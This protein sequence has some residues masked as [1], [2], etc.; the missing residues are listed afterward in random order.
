[1]N[2]RSH[3]SILQY[4]NECFYGNDLEACGNQDINAFIGSP[5]LPNPRYPIIFHAIPGL[6]QR[7]A[8]SPSFFNVDEVLQ[9]K[10]YVE[11]LHRLGTGEKIVSWEYPPVRLSDMIVPDDIGIITPYHGQVLKIRQALANSAMSRVKVASVEEYQ[12]QVRMPAPNAKVPYPGMQE[13]KVII[14]STV[15]S[16]KNYIESDLRHTLG[17]VSHPR[18]FNGMTC[19]LLAAGWANPGIVA[20]TRA[21]ALLIL[22]GDPATLS[23]DP[24]WRRFLTLIHRNGGWTGDEIPWDPENEVEDDQLEEATRIGALEDMRQLAE[25]VEALTLDAAFVEPDDG[26]DD[27]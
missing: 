12:G 25:R 4:S 27:N 20:V 24:L 8:N 13:R 21:K 16:S 26:D 5:L 3:A 17:F 14:I 10:A 15:R 22:V 2:F 6:D 23:L 19:F 9:V 11:E 1:M 7:E 18:R